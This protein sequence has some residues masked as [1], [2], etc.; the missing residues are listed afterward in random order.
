LQANTD[1][2]ELLTDAGCHLQGKVTVYKYQKNKVSA[3][4]GE[5]ASRQ[6]PEG[7]FLGTV[8]TGYYINEQHL[9]VKEVSSAV[10]AM[11][12]YRVLLEEVELLNIIFTN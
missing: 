2:H 4:S 1:L 6:L 11:V 3:S 8:D 10:P 9:I 7:L 5:L 12:L